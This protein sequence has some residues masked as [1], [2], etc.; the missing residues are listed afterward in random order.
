[1]KTIQISFFFLKISYYFKKLKNKNVHI[2]MIN[3][4]Y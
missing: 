4:L 3:Y 1:M 2:Q